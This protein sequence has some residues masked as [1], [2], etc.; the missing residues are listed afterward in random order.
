MVDVSG[1]PLGESL[2][3]WS[4]FS[5]SAGRSFPMCSITVAM[6][7]LKQGTG[8]WS[9]PTHTLPPQIYSFFSSTLDFISTTASFVSVDLLPLCICWINSDSFTSKPWSHTNWSW[10]NVKHRSQVIRLSFQH[11]H[12]P[13][14]KMQAG[15]CTFLRAERCFH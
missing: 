7:P 5:A 6:F 8:V 10:T 2:G 12:T 11:V 9:P 13:E 14:Q 4:A 15:Y 1:Q 3:V